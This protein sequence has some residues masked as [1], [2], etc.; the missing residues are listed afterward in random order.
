MAYLEPNE[1]LLIIIGPSGAGKSS[2]IQKLAGQ[3][4]I[5]VTP[6]W[7]TRPPRGNEA[8]TAIEHKFATAKEFENERGEGHFLDV[9]QLFGL[10]YRYALPKVQKPNSGRVPL[11]MLR[12]S[13]LPLLSKHYSNYIVYQ[14]EDE[15]DRVEKRIRAREANGE[16]QGSRLKDYQKEVELGRK[17]ADRVFVNSSELQALVDSLSQAIRQEFGR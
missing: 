6:S 10:P 5:V 9:V 3:N 4:L 2:A 1:P 11:I 7:T 14:I 12:V 8:E 17:V 15:Y 16:E 13:L